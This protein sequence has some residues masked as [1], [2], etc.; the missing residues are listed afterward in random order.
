M[1]LFK[2]IGAV[3]LV[4]CLKR[5]IPEDPEAVVE[6]GTVCVSRVTRVLLALFPFSLESSDSFCPVG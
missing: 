6:A 5:L 4:L 2:V 3:V 1:P